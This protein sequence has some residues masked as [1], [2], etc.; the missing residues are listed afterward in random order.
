MDSDPSR[1]CNKIRN[2]SFYCFQGTYVDEIF[3]MA[4]KYFKILSKDTH[5]CFSMGP[6]GHLSCILTCSHLSRDSQKRLIMDQYSYLTN[7]NLIQKN[8][9]FRNFLCSR[10]KFSWIYKSKLDISCAM[11]TIYKVIK[12]YFNSRQTKLVKGVNTF[13]FQEKETGSDL[14]SN[15]LT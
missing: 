4:D 12:A 8:K 14:Y 1:C 6:N 11:S 15:I 5:Y 7:R 13:L 3:H 10:M 2:G 9:S